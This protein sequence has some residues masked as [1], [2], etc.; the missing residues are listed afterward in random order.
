[1]II[2]FI[3]KFP[4]SEDLTTDIKYNNI[5]IVVDKLIKYIYLISYNKG[6]II[7]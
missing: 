4:K 3:V 7:K 2:D 1:M 5:L 6:F